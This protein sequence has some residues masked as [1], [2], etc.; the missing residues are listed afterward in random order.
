MTFKEW[1][2]KQELQE[3]GTFASGANG[4]FGSVDHQ[5]LQGFL[6]LTVMFLLM[7]PQN[8]LKNVVL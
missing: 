3:V 6:L 1:F 4:G 8:N 5:Y 7:M 2:K